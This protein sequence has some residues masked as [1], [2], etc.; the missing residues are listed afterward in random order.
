MD[1]PSDT[2]NAAMDELKRRK[3]V[4]LSG[5]VLVPFVEHFCFPDDLHREF[6]FLVGD[7][8]GWPNGDAGDCFMWSLYKKLVAKKGWTCAEDVFGNA[9]VPRMTEKAIKRC[10]ELW[11]SRL[12][13]RLADK[14]FVE[15]GK[16]L[17]ELPLGNWEEWLEFV[18]RDIHEQKLG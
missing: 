18:Q 7:Q 9:N 12:D 5:C 8:Y 4:D 16:V 6:A 2:I 17:E 11:I 1:F 3:L 10:N 13:T 15:K 14:D